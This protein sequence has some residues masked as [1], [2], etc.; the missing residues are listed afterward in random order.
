MHDARRVR[1]DEPVEH[2]LPEAGELVPLEEP[3]AP[4]H[5]RRERL[6]VEELHHEEEL[7]VGRLVD[8][9]E[10]RD[11]LALHAAR[12]LGLPAQA[13]HEHGV[14]EGAVDHLERHALPGRQGGR[15][16]HLPHPTA[17]DGVFEAVLSAEDRARSDA[18]GRSE[19]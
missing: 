2:V 3:S 13:L 8:V 11:E 7:P 15:L 14:G 12:G 18:H 16:E 1:V 19:R 4:A 17:T 9:E 5:V 6:T 10:L